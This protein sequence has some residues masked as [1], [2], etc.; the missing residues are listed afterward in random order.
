MKA[1]VLAGGL[2]TRLR[3]SVPDL[4]KAMAP[5][6]GRPFMEYLLDG[7]QAGGIHEV[8]L[9]VGYRSDDIIRHFGSR[10]RGISIGYC[11]EQEPLGTGGAIAYALSH[12]TQ[13][14]VL[15]LNGD[16][17]LDIDYRALLRWYEA[18]PA[19]LA[20]VLCKLPDVTRYG[21]VLT[22]GDVVVGFA[23]KGA[24]GPGLINAG[25]Y[26]V[27]PGIFAEFGLSGKFSF[28][29]DLLQRH[30][31]SLK[32][33]AYVSDAYFIDI[34]VPQDFERAQRELPARVPG[35]RVSAV[36][37]NYNT[38]PRLLECVTAL[39]GEADLAAV[40]VVDN[41][42]CDGSLQP[43]AALEAGEPRLRV[44]RN[45][46]NLGFGAANN[47][48]LRSEPGSDWLLVNPD[49]IV[50][51]G[52][53]T[54]FMRCRERFPDA[55]VMGGLVRN[56]DG[57]E[58]RGCRRDLPQLGTAALR[59]LSVSRLFGRSRWND[60]DLNGSPLPS[61]PEPVGAISG[62][63]MYFRHEALG[64]VGGF[65]EGYFLHCEDLDICKRMADG[66]WQVWFVPDAE[67]VHH[68]GT[69]SR[70]TPLRVNWH[71]HRGMWRYYRK[72]E[73]R[74]RN[75]LV[76]AAVFAG[77]WLR[78]AMTSLRTLAVA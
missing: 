16:T 70:R 46:A 36:V 26:V 69:G 75:A 33:R 52:I 13:E 53:V 67:A 56:P 78:F 9:S 60:F 74:R 29:T 11:V 27:Q 34:G 55:G 76:D 66:G 62:A 20:M 38:G 14:T 3:E 51:P 35:P 48:A 43:I 73:A 22:S 45:P 40:W 25:M 2:G 44:V 24:A 59:T 18:A 1:V 58:Q 8:L 39:L 32:P 17:F 19:R 37:V 50:K 68:Q 12:G 57:S 63:L 5:V 30:C 47:L 10:Y 49:C 4:P 23:E 31:L 21:S 6:A 65:D 77:I 15:V 41:A 71:K 61:T 54:A 7:M 72:F 64:Q 42:S 28:E